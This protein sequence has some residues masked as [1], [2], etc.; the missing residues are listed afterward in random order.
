MNRPLL[1]LLPVAVLAGLTP[2]RAKEPLQLAAVSAT[3]PAVR[4]DPAPSL[5]DPAA[6]K[7]RRYLG[8]M[9]VAADGDALR[10]AV[11][12]GRTYTIDLLLK[13]GVSVD[14]RDESGRTPL[15]LAALSGSTVMTDYLLGK[16]AAPDAADLQGGTALMFA[17]ENSEQRVLQS[18]LKAGASVDLADQAGHRALHRAILGG[19]AGALEALLA[20]GSQPTIS[21]ETEAPLALALQSGKAEL[22]QPLVAH[23]ASPVDWQPET[24]GRFWKAYA[25]G[26]DAMQ[27]LLQ[28]THAAPPALAGATQP[29]LAEAVL[30]RD[31]K[32]IRRLLQWGSDPDTA[33][34]IPADR[35]FID[36]TGQ[37]D[38][39]FYLEEEHGL[40]VLMLAAGLGC[41]DGVAALLEAG[42]SRTARTD[43]YKMVALSFAGRT[44]NAESQRLL[45]GLPVEPAH[46][47]ISIRIS[48]KLQQA[49][50]SKWGEPPIHTSISTG[51]E[52]FPTQTG[53]F[54]ITD[55]HRVKVSSI[56][57]V[58]MPYFMRL[59]GRDFGLH[60][61]Y[62]PGYA[63]SHGCIRVPEKMA[64]QLYGMAQVGTFVTIEP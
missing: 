59:S 23:G 56:Y 3:P 2:G 42:A 55:K 53:R 15:M 4:L 46:D 38:F 54:V 26:D 16:K 28:A 5:P 63:A 43:R 41:T 1:L 11:K 24:T 32:L 12:E 64:R 22:I 27:D 40:N 29:L 9:K 45:L 62:V 13:A 36:T 35:A 19:Q 48:L 60:E 31:A 47:E 50:I 7:A 33:L 10:T 8:Y 17:A 44:G 51:R 34:R 6:E 14:V 37:P 20:A 52:E 61:G 57:D 18:L 58:P 21:E 49:T 25:A 39:R 30:W